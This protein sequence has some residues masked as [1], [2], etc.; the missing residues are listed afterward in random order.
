[1]FDFP[2]LVFLIFVIVFAYS[3]SFLMIIFG[4]VFGIQ[5]MKINRSR[6][7]DKVV[8]SRNFDIVLH[9]YFWV[10]D[11]II[12]YFRFYIFHSFFGNIISCKI[13]SILKYNSIIHLFFYSFFNFEVTFTIFMRQ[14]FISIIFLSC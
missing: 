13:I 4:I 2:V 10:E 14:Y 11:L 8:E 7:K 3:L 6:A 5:F 9:F 1:M 12:L